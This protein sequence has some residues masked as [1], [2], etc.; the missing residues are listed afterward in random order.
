MICYLITFSLID[1]EVFHKNREIFPF[2]PLKSFGSSDLFRLLDIFPGK[3]VYFLQQGKKIILEENSTLHICLLF[4]KASVLQ[5]Q[6]GDS[7]L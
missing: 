4:R 5:L 1:K 3:H 6:K 2:I 7:T